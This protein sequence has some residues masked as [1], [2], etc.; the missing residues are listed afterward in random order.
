[1]G[2]ANTI[3]PH[4][5]YSDY[6]HWEGRWELIEGHPI[7]MS[8]QPVPKHQRT[9]A[10]LIIAFGNALKAFENWAVYDPIDYKISEDTILQPDILIVH[11]EIKKPYLNFAPAL[12]IEI[13]SPSTAARDRITKFELYQ[14]QAVQYYLIVDVDAEKIEIYELQNGKY[15]LRLNEAHPKFSFHLKNDCHITPDFSDVWS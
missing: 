14:T 10:R 3:L 12:V 8:P 1:M 15:Q 9:S 7:A 13:L 11:G 6:L 4:Y 5:T 2:L